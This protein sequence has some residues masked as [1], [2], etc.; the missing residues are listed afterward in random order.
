M[1]ILEAKSVSIRYITGDFK[2]IG[3]KEYILR[4]IKGNYH[5]TEFWADQNI[6]FSLERGEML[7]IIGT[8]GAGKSTLL[9]A[10]SGIMEPTRGKI[11]RK[12]SIA[13]LLEL[14]TGFDGELTVKENTYLRG[15]M[16]GYTRAFMD[17]TYRQIIDF[18]ELRD[19][20]DRPFKQL[21]SGMKSRLG[22]A[23]A[24]L[25]KPD[26]L[27]LDEVLAVG[28]GAFRKKS[29]A[30]MKEIIG[31]GATTILVS[32]SLEQVRIMCDKVLWLHKGRQIAYGDNV[33][34]ICDRYQA[35]LDGKPDAETQSML[36]KIAAAAKPCPA[37]EDPTK[38]SG[39]SIQSSKQSA[40]AQ[41]GVA[42][43]EH[44]P[45]S[46]TKPTRAQLF[47]ELSPVLLMML[48]SFC[49][50]LAMQ[51][52]FPPQFSPKIWSLDNILREFRYSLNGT[53]VQTSVMAALLFYVGNRS[54]KVGWKH[55]TGTAVLSV[56]LALLWLFS[57]AADTSQVFRATMIGTPAQIIKSVLYFFGMSWFLFLCGQLLYRICTR[58]ASSPKSESMLAAA[59]TS[60][61]RPL[62]R[63]MTLLLAAWLPYLI[64]D[65]PA[66]ISWDTWREMNMFFGYWPLT[67]HD[68]PAHTVLVSMVAKLGMAM[69]NVNIAFCAFVLVQM[70]VGALLISYGLEIMRQLNAP[71]WMIVIA[72][73]AG[74]FGIPIAYYSVEILKDCQYVHFF[75]LMILCFALLLKDHK[76]FF[77]CKRNVILFSVSIY[78]VLLFRKNGKY[79]VWLL[80]AAAL[81]WLLAQVRKK[82]MPWLKSLG[83]KPFLMLLVPVLIAD[84]TVS[85]LVRYYGFGEA[86]IREAFSLPFQQTA[87]YVSEYADEIPPEEEEAIDAVLNYK[88]LPE[89]YLPTKSDDVKRTFKNDATST[90]LLTYFE[91][92]FKQF[93]RH[94]MTY[95]EAT[96]HQTYPLYYPFRESIRARYGTRTIA[97]F[98]KII[99]DT[100]YMVDTIIPR[101]NEIA[102]QYAIVM[103]RLPILGLLSNQAVYT[104]VLLYL[105]LYAILD[106]KKKFLWLVSPLILSVLVCFL[107]PVVLDYERYAFPFIYSTP[108]ALA[109]FH[110][111]YND[112]SLSKCS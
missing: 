57:V 111:S 59:R 33:K 75:L 8:N 73:L 90:D 50:A 58:R 28:D 112:S 92:W 77:G 32:H 39:S 61:R 93:V 35:F 108:V 13:A 1:S 84:L 71:G 105:T 18:A 56:L 91:T 52:A 87:R 70:F 44:K 47:K 64:L 38:K 76:A 14:S 99:A 40:A 103:Y 53:I 48:L 83:K 46:L 24:C 55:K 94:P 29:E 80:M 6:S 41:K 100:G 96:I 45:K 86:S 34:E 63:D 31:S 36:N 20:E 5:V 107:A 68:P 69:G 67:A 106:R 74:R 51:I 4:Q 62:L 66:R 85:G 27:I 43:P 60:R 11:I 15:A 98:E 65:F 104:I 54:R 21:S 2:D 88:K 49:G 30:K 95:V 72:Q 110:A 37:K 23:I 102:Q 19:F 79:I 109:F 17:K 3:I 22:F 89:L 9:K 26:I 101:G 10:V 25:V 81:I 16:M 42:A 7:G 82:G 12:G 97:D 78:G